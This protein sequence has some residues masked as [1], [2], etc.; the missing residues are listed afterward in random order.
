MTFCFELCSL[1]NKSRSSLKPVERA[2]CGPGPPLKQLRSY[3]VE[4][5]GNCNFAASQLGRSRQRSVSGN[6]SSK[7]TPVRR[8]DDDALKRSRLH[9]SQYELSQDL[10]DKQVEMLERKYGGVCARKAALT[11]QR[12]FRKYTIMKRFQDIANASKGEKRLSRRFPTFDMENKE[13]VVYNSNGTVSRYPHFQHHQ[14]CYEG[15][16]KLCNNFHSNINSDAVL[17]SQYN[18]LYRELNDTL[19][20]DD[21]SRYSKPCRTQSFRER[22]IKYQDAYS[23]GI[24]M[25]ECNN[26]ES[27]EQYV[28]KPVSHLNSAYYQDAYQSSVTRSPP[29]FPRHPA[30]TAVPN[31]NNQ[32]THSASNQSPSVYVHSSP[33]IKVQHQPARDSISSEDSSLSSLSVDIDSSEADSN[34][35]RGTSA[36]HSLNISPSKMP[37]SNV[38]QR[39]AARAS[40]VALSRRV[41]PRIDQKKIPPQVPKRTS[42][43]PSRDGSS[44]SADGTIS[45]NSQQITGSNSTNKTVEASPVWK[46]KSLVLAEQS[47]SV[48]DKRLSNISENS[49]DSLDSGG[50]YSN[51]PPADMSHSFNAHNYPDIRTPHDLPGTPTIY[52]LTEIQRKR[53]Y[54]VGLN[55]FNKKPERGVRYL[56]QRGFLEASPQ[57]VARFLLTRKGL[58]K[59]MIGEYLGNL[60]N[61]FN[62]AVLEC[63]VQELDLAGMQVDVALRKFQTFFRMPGEAQKIERLVE[64][65]SHRY[66]DCNHDIA[67]KFHNPET[68]FVLAF[69]IIMLNTDLHTPN[70]KAE[71]RMKLEEFIR[72]LRSIDDGHDL[73]RDMLVG[74][75]ERIKTNE[76]KMGSDHVTQVLKVQQTIVGKKPNLALPHRRLVCYCRLYEVYDVSKKERPGVHQREVFLFNDLLMVTKIFSKKKNSVTYTFRQ[77]FPLCGMSVTLFEAPYYPHGIRLSQRVDDKV[78]ITFNARNEHD[79]SKFVEDLKESILEMDEM[80]NLRIEGEL[81]KQKMMRVRGAENRDSG[82]ADMEIIP[83]PTKDGKLSPESVASG[84]NLKRSALSNSLL[85]LH[86]QQINKPVR[87]GSAGSLD[88]G[89][90]SAA[91]SVSHD[92]SPQIVHASSTSS[93]SGSSLGSTR[94]G[95]ES[96]SKQPSSQAG[97]LG[98]LFSKK[99]KHTSKSNSL[100]YA[101]KPQTL[102]HLEDNIRR[103]IADIRPQRLEKVIEDWTSRLDYIR[104]SRGSPMPEIIF[105][106]S[107]LVMVW[108]CVWLV[109]SS[110]SVPLKTRRVGQR[111][112]LNLSRAETSS[113]W[114]GAVVRR[115]GASSGVVLI[116]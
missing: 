61:S 40:D 26:K 22:R 54:R 52:K 53:Q 88:S 70:M 14:S 99:G 71:R 4:S 108:D 38:L 110:S 86:E 74:I 12:A 87:R 5:N 83:Q 116:N 67:S 11:I 93:G 13:W 39:N 10:L 28:G 80:E 19:D 78:L 65:F 16:V 23:Q 25:K 90:S 57:A 91:S 75:Y 56:I 89:M 36:R 112:T 95:P 102:D 114:C 72:N 109:T 30:W 59:Q 6:V 20:S 41:S 92:S 34:I 58:S 106:I 100:V 17:Q 63:F 68:V 45:E 94:S 43:I 69:A 35:H 29:A 31:A 27:Y 7:K 66:I 3:S 9:N 37:T 50:G 82:V 84:N 64:V 21:G 79:R 96:T 42:S 51:T 98:G 103:V 46:R 107:L 104:A 85:D 8:V 18:A 15:E 24:Y 111:C 76:F 77:S 101:D 97:F 81:E 33:S 113:R 32:R 55:L 47:V 115:G 44:E 49:E 2:S 60:Q 73:D 1:K 62:M 105:K 48:E